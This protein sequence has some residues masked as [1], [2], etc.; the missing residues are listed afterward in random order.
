MGH[1]KEKT[2]ALHYNTEN[3]EVFYFDDICVATFGTKM[4]HPGSTKS[5]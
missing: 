5:V 3:L 4:G 1:G 2:P